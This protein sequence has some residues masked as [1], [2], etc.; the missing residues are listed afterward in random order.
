M[1]LIQKH[2]IVKSWANNQQVNWKNDTL[3]ELVLWEKK[4]ADGKQ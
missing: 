2:P 3:V 1:Q 4:E